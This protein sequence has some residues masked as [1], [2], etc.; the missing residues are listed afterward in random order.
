[1][2]LDSVNSINSTLIAD[3]VCPSKDVDGL[4]TV[5]QG[6]VAVGDLTSGFVPCTPSGCIEL[7]KRFV[8]FTFTNTEL[9]VGNLV[10]L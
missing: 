9:A 10:D 6:K 3:S 8:L 1:M 7:I 4:N 5:N 2:P